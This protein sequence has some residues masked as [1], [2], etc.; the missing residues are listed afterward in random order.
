MIQVMKSSAK[1]WILMSYQELKSTLGYQRFICGLNMESEMKVKQTN[2]QKVKVVDRSQGRNVQPTLWKSRSMQQKKKD[3]ELF[4]ENVKGY[5]NAGMM[6]Q[7]VKIL[8]KAL[9]SL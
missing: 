2:K 8:M 6:L 3:T 9:W 7:W 1:F 5:S 4:K